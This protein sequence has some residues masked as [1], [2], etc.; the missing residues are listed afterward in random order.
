MVLFIYCIWFF[1]NVWFYWYFERFIIVIAIVV[2]IIIILIFISEK[3]II[4]LIYVYWYAFR[5]LWIY[6]HNSNDLLEI[7]LQAFVSHQIWVIGIK[8]LSS[9]RIISTLYLYKICLSHSNISSYIFFLPYI[10]LIYRLLLFKLEKVTQFEKK[11][12]LTMD[13]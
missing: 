11:K 5:N 13:S 3:L 12:Y 1:H 10:S 2:V 6:S 9:E 4:V 8:L 7:K